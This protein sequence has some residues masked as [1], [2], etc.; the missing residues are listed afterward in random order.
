MKV[1]TQENR[2]K[3]LPINMTASHT[4]VRRLTVE[5]EA[6]VKSWVVQAR[7][8]IMLDLLVVHPGPRTNGQGSSTIVGC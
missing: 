6:R 4:E 8:C 5:A 1:G 3:S 2:A 7:G